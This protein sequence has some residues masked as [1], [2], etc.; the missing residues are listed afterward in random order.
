MNNVSRLHYKS[1]N[2]LKKLSNLVLFFFLLPSSVQQLYH[3]HTCPYQ[4]GILP[5]HVRIHITTQK[6]TFKYLIYF[7]LM[8]LD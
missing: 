2:H 5:L 4:F 6:I 7:N 8:K 3:T 1:I